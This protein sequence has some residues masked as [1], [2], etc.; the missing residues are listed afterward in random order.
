VLPG[1]CHSGEVEMEGTP[2]ERLG[3]FISDALVAEAGP[4]SVPSNR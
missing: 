1:P 4:E 3:Q 2:V